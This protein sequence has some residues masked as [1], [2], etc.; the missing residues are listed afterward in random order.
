MATNKERYEFIEAMFDK[1]DSIS[2]ERIVGHYI[3]LIPKGRHWMGLCPFHMDTK[4]GSFI[5]TPD[6][7][8]W[9]CFSCGDDYAGN[10]VKFV[11]LYKHITYLDAAFDTALEFGL[12]SY[13]EYRKYS[14]KSMMRIM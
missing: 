13:D 6:R 14:K 2:V 5:V 7:G 3:K 4:L 12:I 10:G 11:S 8:I 9:K 1:L